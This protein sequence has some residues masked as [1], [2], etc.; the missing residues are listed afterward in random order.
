MINKEQFKIVSM[1]FDD[2][3]GI[4]EPVHEKYEA[5]RDLRR[6][7]NRKKVLNVNVIENEFLKIKKEN[8]GQGAVINNSMR[9]D[10][11]S[12][13][14]FGS[15]VLRL[16]QLPHKEDKFMAMKVKNT[17]KKRKELE[18]EEQKKRVHKQGSAANSSED[19]DENGQKRQTAADR[20]QGQEVES[21]KQTLEDLVSK[22]PRK[23]NLM[24]QATLLRDTKVTAFESVNQQ[25][26]DSDED[27]P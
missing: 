9:V 15:E 1:L 4:H 25:S 17:K 19:E 14:M 10:D 7:L 3:Y 22:S 2:Y 23:K 5:I 6:K 13:L 20:I 26:A 18:L 21:L 24:R 11:P 27:D 12:M 16:L 8:M